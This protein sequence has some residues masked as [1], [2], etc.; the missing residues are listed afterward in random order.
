MTDVDKAMQYIHDSCSTPYSLIP[1]NA[2][3]NDSRTVIPAP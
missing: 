3:P 1:C 2:S